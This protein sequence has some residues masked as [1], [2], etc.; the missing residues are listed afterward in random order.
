MDGQTMGH[1]LLAN[2]GIEHLALA[3]ALHR[4]S[5]R[6]GHRVTVVAD[7]SVTL[8][9]LRAQGLSPVS[10]GHAHSVSLPSVP[11]DGFAA[12]E[13]RCTGLDPTAST[14]ATVRAR[15]RLEKRAGALVRLVETALPDLVVL[16]DARD[17]ASRLFDWT[18]REF[19]CD[20]L[21]L[22]QGLL[23]GTL[24]CD[25][26]GI[27]GDA[28]TCDRPAIAYRDASADVPFLDDVLASTLAGSIPAPGPAERRTPLW[29]PDTFDTFLSVAEGLS[30]ARLTR[31]LERL[32]AWRQVAAGRATET[33][34]YDEA[35]LPDFELLPREPFVAVLL[36]RDDDLR[37]RIDAPASGSERG[38]LIATGVRV[39][40]LLGDGRSG[41][42]PL[43]IVRAPGDAESP[44]ENDSTTVAVRAATAATAA[45]MAA[46][47]VTVNHPLALVGV[48]AGTPVLH[49][50][51]TPYAVPG[52]AT[53]IG[54]RPLEDALA[55]AVRRSQPA[56]R[57]RFST[58]LLR[59][60]HLWCAAS[61]PDGN[62]LRGLADALRRKLQRRPDQ[63]AVEPSGYRPGPAFL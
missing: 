13:L 5:L 61:H 55:E 48:L 20:L 10:L 35:A 46:A 30:R 15:A 51:R 39:A 18:A 6:D 57:A 43:V 42:L 23:P 40:E 25:P 2:P 37:L 24:Q 32:G 17:G 22:G 4:A 44:P 27:D 50:G 9:A 3:I 49:S 29:A 41:T 58:H 59:Q 31:A 1:V 12:R 28:S 19:G 53:R 38:E 26:L 52:V 21:H 45:A 8:R 33:T 54:E 7:E 11:L 47:V 14:G 36:Q 16:F 62:G 63:L 34:A 60:D 56:L